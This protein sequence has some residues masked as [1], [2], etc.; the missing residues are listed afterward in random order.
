MKSLDLNGP[1]FDIA[2]DPLEQFTAKGEG[3]A[4]SVLQFLKKDAYCLPD[5]YMEKIVNVY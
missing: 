4:F 1:K 3:N 5:T 2:V